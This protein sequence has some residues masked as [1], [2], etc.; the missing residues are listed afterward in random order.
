MEE[1]CIGGSTST[2]VTIFPA[3]SLSLSLSLCLSLSPCSHVKY[4]LL[5][6][7]YCNLS[8]TLLLQMHNFHYNTHPFTCLRQCKLEYILFSLSLI[9]PIFSHQLQLSCLHST[10][11]ASAPVC[12]YTHTHTNAVKHLHFPF[13]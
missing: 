7:I 1:A 2:Y 8:L 6:H 4:T 5:P 9:F 13:L 11:T 12:L 3:L 10:L